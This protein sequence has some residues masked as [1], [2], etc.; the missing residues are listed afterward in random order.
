MIWLPGVRW[1]AFEEGLAT[2]CK[3]SGAGCILR[4]GA[5]KALEVLMVWDLDESGT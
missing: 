2:Y 1:R 3:V 5:P 4:K